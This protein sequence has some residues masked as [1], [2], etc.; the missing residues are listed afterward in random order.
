MKAIFFMNEG[1]MHQQKN[2]LPLKN[3]RELN[4]TLVI[5]I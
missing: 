2:S 4:Q 1:L 3:S 5:T